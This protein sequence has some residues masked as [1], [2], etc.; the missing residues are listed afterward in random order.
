VAAPCCQEKDPFVNNPLVQPDPGLF[1]WTIFTFLVLVALLAK[2]AWRPLLAALDARQKMIAKSI[3]D[4]EKARTDLERVQQD[5]ARILAAARVEGE[6]IVARSRAAADRLGD[7]L[8]QKAVAEAAGLLKKAE[9]D[10][11]LETSRA[12]EQVRRETIELSVAIASKIL[13][14]N[15]SADDNRALIDDTIRQLDTTRH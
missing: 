11:Q 6:A 2:F 3:D 5:A 7:E 12:I 10:I 8:R 15:V 4:A 14:R 1:I 13:H 9:R